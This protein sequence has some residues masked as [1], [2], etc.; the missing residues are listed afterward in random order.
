MTVKF[1]LNSSVSKT[2]KYN[3]QTD[4]LLTVAAG[5]F[6][7][8]EHIYRKHLGNRLTDCKVGYSNGIVNSK[9]GGSIT[10]EKVCAGNTN[11]AE[12]LQISYNPQIITLKELVDF[13]FRMHDPTTANSQGPDVGTQYRSAL[14]A[15]SESDL[16]ELLKLKA[17]W[18]AK[19]HNSIITEVAMTESFYDAETYHQLYLNKNPVGYQCPSHYLRNI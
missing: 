16:Q 19:W 6:W 12:V 2:I 15:H 9:D 8:T 17:E 1:M 13:F 5:C 7:G 3:P 18:Q 11:F 10:Y 14:F 4:K